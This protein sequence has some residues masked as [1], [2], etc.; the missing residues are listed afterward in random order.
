MVAWFAT[1]PFR[2]VSDFRIKVSRQTI[3]SNRRRMEAA[4][5][6]GVADPGSA[7]FAALYAAAPVG[8]IVS[9]EVPTISPR[10]G[11]RFT[12]K[13]Y[14]LVDR[15]SYSNTVNVAAIVQD[16]GFGTVMGEETADLATTY[17]AMESFDLPRTGLSVGYA[18]AFLIRPNGSLRPRGVVPDV[19][20]P[21]PV[22]LGKDEVLEEA[23]AA[24]AAKAGS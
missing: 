8:G 9:F 3:A 22:V 21:T 1:R 4:A 15:Y 18:K 6:A 13:V 11:E 10:D 14:L 7:R 23:L 17:G 5:K 19:A 2:F 20:I 24:I 16:Y 12:G